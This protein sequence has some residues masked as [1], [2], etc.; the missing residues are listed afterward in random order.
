MK[1][2]SKFISYKDSIISKFPIFLSHLESVDLSVLELYKKTR[3]DVDNISE[4]MDI[5]DCLYVLGKI[6]FNGEVLHYVKEN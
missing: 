4:F 2:P 6:D 3:K 1:L 5:L